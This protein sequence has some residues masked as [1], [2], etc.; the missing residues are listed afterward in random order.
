MPLCSN[1]AE[2]TVRSEA[3]RFCFQASDSGASRVRTTMSSATGKPTKKTDFQP[4]AG[5]MVCM[6]TAASR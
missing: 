1:M 5:V 3:G 2:K 4:R 6:A